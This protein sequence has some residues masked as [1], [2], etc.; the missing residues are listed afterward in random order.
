MT[1]FLNRFSL[2]F[3]AFVYALKYVGNHISEYPCLILLLSFSVFVFAVR[4]IKIFD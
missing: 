4:F 1:V 2:V 3:N